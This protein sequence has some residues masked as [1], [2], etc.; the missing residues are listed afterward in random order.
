MIDLLD[1][2]VDKACGKLPYD[3]K[4]L[5]FQGVDLAD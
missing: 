2:K 5:C 3:Q 1:L 4:D